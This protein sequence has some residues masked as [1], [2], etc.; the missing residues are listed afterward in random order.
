MCAALDALKVR[1]DDEAHTYLR[2]TRTLD[3][4]SVTRSR[5]QD[6]YD[7]LKSVETILKNM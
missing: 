4:P 7:G 5:F 2:I 6:I 3:A 1:R